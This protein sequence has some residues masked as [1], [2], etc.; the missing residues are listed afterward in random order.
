MGAVIWK[1]KNMLCMELPKICM[2]ARCASFSCLSREIVLKKQDQS[3]MKS[4][5]RLSVITRTI[6]VLKMSVDKTDLSQ[7]CDDYGKIKSFLI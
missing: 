5:A 7:S 4:V 2:C 1:Y 6:R 3:E